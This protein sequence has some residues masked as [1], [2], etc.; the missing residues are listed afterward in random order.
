MAESA[1]TLFHFTGKRA[2]KGI[3]KNGFYPRYYKEN[4]S[5]AT[6]RISI[7]KESFVPMVCFCDLP[8]SR[9]IDHIR[10]YGEYGIGMRKE[11]WGVE[12]GISPIIYLPESSSSSVQFQDIAASISRTISD[13]KESLFIRQQL[14]NFYKYIKP[15]KG[16][17]WNKKKK[18]KVPVT[19]YHEREWRYV[20][21]GFSIVSD[22][23]IIPDWIEK[24]NETLKKKEHKLNFD[25]NN[26]KYIV[27]KSEHEIPAFTHFINK[28]LLN[29][30]ED[31]RSLLASKLISVTQ[32]REDM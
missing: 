19:F 10:F 4:L 23:N 30:N 16:E 8:M 21:D 7:Y 18:K 25:A 26:V 3:L 5:T 28:N 31:E 27:V 13:F 22:K 12:R 17:T 9:I 20:P 29:F 2:L 15:Y 32:I 6:P 11:G 24:A 1:N 14:L